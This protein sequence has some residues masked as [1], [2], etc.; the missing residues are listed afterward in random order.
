MA[1]RNV[2]PYV[3]LVV[4]AG[5]AFHV[6]S[7]DQARSIRQT[8][9]AIAVN[10]EAIATNQA[11]TLAGCHTEQRGWDSRHE[12]ILVVTEPLAT[13]P[14]SPANAAII[15]RNAKYADER[16]RLLGHGGKRPLC[17]APVHLPVVPGQ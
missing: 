12:I 13:I 15:A 4:G 1:W 10:R 8:R 16:V 2:V 14:G 6:R 9:A 7:D 5:F 3:V 11:T 17:P